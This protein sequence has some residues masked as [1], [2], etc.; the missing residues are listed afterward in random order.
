MNNTRQKWIVEQARVRLIKD[1]CNKPLCG[2]CGQH[3]ESMTA[4]I[5]SFE[6]LCQ[7]IK[8]E[9]SDPQK[10][11]S[12]LSWRAFRGSPDHGPEVA[13]DYELIKKAVDGL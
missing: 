12:R 4:L 10:A 3:A 1:N 13:R 2:C 8:D 9:A 7:D 6:E 11:L 5:D